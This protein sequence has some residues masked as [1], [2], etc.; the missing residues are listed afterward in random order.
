MF[1][2]L[3]YE[4][5]AI[6]ILFFFFFCRIWIVKKWH[7]FGFQIIVV[8]LKTIK[9]NSK[10]ISKHFFLMDCC[11]ICKNFLFLIISVI[12]IGIISIL[13]LFILI[14]FQTLFVD[15]LKSYQIYFINALVLSL[16]LLICCVIFS[17]IN[18]KWAKNVVSII[19]VV[20]NIIILCFAIIIFVFGSKLE[21]VIGEEAFWNN[22]HGTFEDF[23][24]CC[25]WEATNENCTCTGD[26]C[27]VT[28]KAQINDKFTGNVNIIGGVM[29]AIFAVVLGF[30][31][32]FFYVACRMKSSREDSDSQKGQFNTPLTYGW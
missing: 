19:L 11:T 4:D 21:G 1:K 28:C 15:E 20:Y 29:I 3:L 16:I 10:L 27:N 17:F 14:R 23:F 8:K 7:L 22:H 25:G 12:T 26:A 24:K 9:I 6:W 31:I 13:L 5:K 2:Y 32:F 18:Q 30:I